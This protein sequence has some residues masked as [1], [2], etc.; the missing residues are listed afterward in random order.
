MKTAL[1]IFA[2]LFLLQL[3]A[4][5]QGT[6]NQFN[7]NSYGN[8]S[9]CTA[10]DNT[11]ISCYNGSYSECRV[12]HPNGFVTSGPGPGAV[13]INWLVERHRQHVTDKAIDNAFA[14]VLLTIRHSMH[15]MDLSA[16][17]AALTPYVPADQKAVA[18]KMTAYLSDQSEQFSRGVSLFASRW[19]NSDRDSFLRSAKKLDELYDS[20]LVTACRLREIS[21]SLTSQYDPLRSKLTAEIVGPLDAV[22]ADEAYFAAE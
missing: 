21:H 5:A 9:D 13:L 1:W 22:E 18:Q 10:S 14:T 20:G 8:Y 11:R 16:F 7:C 2:G 12:G 6:F 3:N 15:L 17:T 19:N 4:I